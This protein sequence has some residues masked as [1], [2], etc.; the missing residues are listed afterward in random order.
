MKL[1]NEITAPMAGTV[2]SILFENG[3]LA[4]YGA[5]LITLNTTSATVPIPSSSRPP[6]SVD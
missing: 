5:P 4:E 6:D 3:T 1:L 2:D